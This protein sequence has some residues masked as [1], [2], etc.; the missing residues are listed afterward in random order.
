MINLTEEYAKTSLT[1]YRKMFTQFFIK[2]KNNS[3]REIPDWNKCSQ[4]R[5]TGLTLP[6]TLDS[7]Y[8][9]LEFIIEQRGLGLPVKILP[10]IYSQAGSRQVYYCFELV[11]ILVILYCIKEEDA[12]LYSDEKVIYYFQFISLKIP[13]LTEDAKRV[14]SLTEGEIETIRYL[15]LGVVGD[16]PE[17][18][19]LQKCS[20]KGYI[21]QLIEV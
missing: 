21:R 18:V 17:S 2:F 9:N 10:N 3:T 5:M 12:S 6:L 4:K 19:R 20:N 1:M 8:Q 13:M 16:S 14:R 7:K 15:L 11:E